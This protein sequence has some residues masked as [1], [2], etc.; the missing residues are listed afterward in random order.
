ME[1]FEDLTTSFSIKRIR[2]L[3]NYLIIFSVQMLM[4]IGF[5]SIIVSC[6]RLGRPGVSTEM[7]SLFLRK[8][9]LYVVVLISIQMMMLLCNYYEIYNP[10]K[11]GNG[12]FNTA[13]SNVE[14]LTT[15][16]FTLI[17]GT[18]IVMGIVRTYE[19]YYRFLLKSSI[20]SWFGFVLEE[21]ES[22]IKA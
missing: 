10:I 13:E 18:G 9:M 19:P 22:G 16:S 2:F 20:F 15:I 21:P 5:Y 4:I 1:V 7:R 14:L 3:Y 11:K 6:R 17:F 8:H 12:D